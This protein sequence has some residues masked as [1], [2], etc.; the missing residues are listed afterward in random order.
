MYRIFSNCVRKE[1]APQFGGSYVV[2][3]VRIFKLRNSLGRRSCIDPLAEFKAIRNKRK[4]GRWFTYGSVYE[5][6]SKN[7]RWRITKA[8]IARYRSARGK[9]NNR[10]E[11]GECREGVRSFVADV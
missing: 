10:L 11:G 5:K 2:L 8:L 4:K 1:S 6:G 3:K 7:G 9:S